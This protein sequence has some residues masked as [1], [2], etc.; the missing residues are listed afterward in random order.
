MNRDRGSMTVWVAAVLALIGLSVGVALAYGTAVIGRH[1]AE[2]AA[3][4]AALAA[5]AHV[6]DGPT[7]AC[8]TA[9]T[10]ATRNG[11]AVRTCRVAGTDVEVV[12]YRVV[13]LAGLGQHT[14][15]VRAR[16]GPVTPP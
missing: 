2:T 12:V 5:A 13:D 14:V 8:R 7:A 16:A 6:P 10:V 4:L 15:V 9:A 1:R 3:D 11:S